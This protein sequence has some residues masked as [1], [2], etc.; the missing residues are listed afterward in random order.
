MRKVNDE[1]LF[2]DEPMVRLGR[3]DLESLKEQ[4]LKNER[5]RVRICAHRE[6]GDRVHEMLI[7]M[8]KGQYVRPHKHLANPESFHVIE[9]SVDI[10]N[11][12]EAGAIVSRIGLGDYASGKEFF[13]RYD[14]T[15]FH[16]VLVNSDFFIY[17]ETKSG[18]FKREDTILAS[19]APEETDKEGAARFMRRLMEH[20]AWR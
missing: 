11:F 16:T 18:P 19:W 13:Y 6:E 15:Y 14:E 5:R 2:A 10:F 17:H 4:A 20:R 3:R 9:G 7:V 8:A 12:D 1:V